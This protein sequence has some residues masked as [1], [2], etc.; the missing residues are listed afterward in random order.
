MLDGGARSAWQTS[1]VVAAVELLHH[2]RRNLRGRRHAASTILQR[3]VNDMEETRRDPA[4]AISIA[5]AADAR[6]IDIQGGRIVFED[7]TFHYGGHATPLYDGLSV[8]IGAGERVGLVGRSGSG[9]T[10]F[11]QRKNL[12]GEL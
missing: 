8:D 9:K 5:D 2:P 12:L 7:V 3:S 10:A 6:P 4:K 11:V 1:P